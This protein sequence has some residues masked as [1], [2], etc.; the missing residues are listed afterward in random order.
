MERTMLLSTRRDH[1]E[2]RIHSANLLAQLARNTVAVDVTRQ[3]VWLERAKRLIAEGYAKLADRTRP[4]SPEEL[5]NDV[6]N[7]AYERHARSHTIVTMTK[8]DDECQEISSVARVVIGSSV[9]NGLAPID[10]MNFVEPL[11]AWPHRA[12]GWDDSRAAEIGRFVIADKYKTG[13]MRKAGAHA[14]LTR[15]LFDR[16]AAVANSRGTAGFYA[17]L[18]AYSKTLLG[19]TGVQ[20]REIPSRL[21]TEDARAADIFSR[22]SLYWERSA[23]RLYLLEGPGLTPPPVM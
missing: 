9:T 17:I 20:L 12:L 22:Y 5:F 11:T 16:C 7:D 19:Q 10:A 4:P 2:A 23:P 21:R 18:P 6:C 3:P 15:R 13:P 8:A 1:P 14:F